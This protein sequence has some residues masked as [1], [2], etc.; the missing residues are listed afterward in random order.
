[1]K[2]FWAS[3]RRRFV[4]IFIVASIAGIVNGVVIFNITHQ[5]GFAVDAVPG[6]MAM[7]EQ[8][9]IIIVDN[10]QDYKYFSSFATDY[11]VYRIENLPD[12][13]ER[14]W[15]VFGPDNPK[16]SEDPNSLIPGYH[17]VSEIIDNR[18]SA[19][20]LEKL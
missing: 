8:D 19:F 16:K 13:V 20:E 7:S 6:I 2:R 15:Y 9:K 14:A 18:Y 12:D 17:V 10:E 3:R 5:F 1:M 11:A 4:M